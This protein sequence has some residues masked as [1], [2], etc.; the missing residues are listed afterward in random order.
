MPLIFEGVKLDCGCIIDILVENKKFELK[1]TKVINLLVNNAQI[2]K[3]GLTFPFE[4][5]GRN[6]ARSSEKSSHP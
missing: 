5:T 2:H 1:T 4:F 6:N 3:T